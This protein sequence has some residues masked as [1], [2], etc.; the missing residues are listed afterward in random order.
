[1]KCVEPI[2]TSLNT[3]NPSLPTAS[4]SLLFLAILL[5]RTVLG[6][7]RVLLVLMRTELHLQPKSLPL[8]Q[9]TSVLRL[10]LNDTPYTLLV[11]LLNLRVHFEMTP[12]VLTR[13]VIKV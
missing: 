2:V 12:L 4:L 8:L 13:L 11:I 6:Q 7:P 5:T 9:L 1:M 10:P 3:L